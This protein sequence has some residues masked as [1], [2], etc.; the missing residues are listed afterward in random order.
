[1]I[2]I[3]ER[4]SVI[5]KSFIHKNFNNKKEIKGLKLICR[6]CEESNESRWGIK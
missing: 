5:E 1:M 3:G 6:I 4:K 2:S